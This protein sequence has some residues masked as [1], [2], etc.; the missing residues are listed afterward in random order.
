MPF[1]LVSY[2]EN[3][4]V[5]INAVPIAW[6]ND[7]LLFWPPKGANIARLRNNESSSPNATWSSRPC[8]IKVLN[9]LDHIQVG[10]QLEKKYINF[11]DSES[12]EM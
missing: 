1:K 10:I 3:N 6:E 2:T 5:Y 8:K 11:T 12:E 9:N 7:G 4:L